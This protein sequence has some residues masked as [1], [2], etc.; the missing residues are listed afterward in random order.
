MSTSKKSGGRRA[1]AEQ[2]RREEQ[3]RQRRSTFLVIGSSVLVAALILGFVG[4]QVA[5]TSQEDSRTLTEIGASAGD[6]G[7][8]EV[9]TRPAKGNNDHRQE[10][11]PI[12]YDAAPPAS[13]PHWPQFLVGNQIRSFWTQDDRPPVERL[14]HSLEHGHTILWYDESAVAD[15]ATITDVEA[16]SGK[17]FTETGGKFMAAPWSETDGELFPGEARFALTHWSAGR[18]AATPVQQG[19]WQYCA[20]L[21]GEVTERFL[22]D[23]P[24]ADSPEPNAA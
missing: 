20:E 18:E 7:C 11:Q 19:V 16:L 22:E 4:W 21:S 24:P 17:A 14:V 10:G 23:Y 1:I 5:R 3:R 8:Q 12:A 2:V 6:A 13:G 15:E 9:Q